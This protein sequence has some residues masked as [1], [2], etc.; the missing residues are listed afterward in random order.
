MNKPKILNRHW[1]PIA[2]RG[3]AHGVF[4]IDVVARIFSEAK[5][6][7][8]ATEHFP[9]TYSQINTKS[10][11][12]RYMRQVT[13]DDYIRVLRDLEKKKPGALLRAA[14]K[15]EQSALDARQ[16]ADAIASRWDKRSKTKVDL[17]KEIRALYEAYACIAPR[18]Y[19]YVMINRF[20]PDIVSETIARRV[21]KVN[22][23]AEVANS[24]FSCVRTT[25]L[26]KERAALIRLASDVR[27]KRVSRNSPPFSRRVAK[28]AQEFGYLGMYVMFGR[29][30]TSADIKKRV[31]TLIVKGFE[32][33][34]ESVRAQLGRDRKTLKLFSKYKFTASEQR[35]VRTAQEWAYASILGD[36]AYAYITA[37]TLP[38]LYDCAKRLRIPYMV[39][40]SMRFNELISALRSGQPVSRSDRQRFERR[41]STH[42][43]VY[44]QGKIRLYEG[45]SLK[46]FIST[47][48][49]AKVL[50][51]RITELTG[52]VASP[53]IVRGR[54][55]IVQSLGDLKKVRPGNILVAES[56]MPA[57]VSAMERAGA[58]VTEEGGLLSHA[59]IVSRELQVPCVV[60]TKIATKVFKD[61]D[62]VEVDAVKG[63]VKKCS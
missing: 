47:L 51:G 59:A 57:Y 2:K 50:R 40:V 8:R 3:K 29:P 32:R 39:L 14:K 41:L 36:E 33:E 48:R 28:I 35:A 44:E 30:F 43:V 26:L 11:N 18:T 60:G 9:S 55:V 15:Y 58:V 27:A 10:F 45:K 61:G 52:Q 54:V 49:P 31:M 20:Y 6:G 19:H 13:I 38:M 37:R 53:G 62:R 16:R 21:P 42:A 1:E 46:G 17:T 4:I 25:G 34:S 7:L 23:Q 63:I 5:R 24:F 22:E 12:G 56:T